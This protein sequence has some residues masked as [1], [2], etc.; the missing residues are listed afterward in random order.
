MLGKGVNEL[1]LPLSLKSCV[2]STDLSSYPPSTPVLLLETSRSAR[3]RTSFDCS[4]HGRPNF[5]WW[6]T[7]NWEGLWTLFSL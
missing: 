2:I 4:S 1:A 5:Y 3:R 6:P 7:G